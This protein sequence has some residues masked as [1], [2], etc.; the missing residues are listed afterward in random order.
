ME[1]KGTRAVVDE[2]ALSKSAAHLKAAKSVD[3]PDSLSYDRDVAQQYAALY[4]K[5]D[6]NL[7]DLF[8]ELDESPRK[9]LKHP[10]DDAHDF[11]IKYAQGYYTFAEE[12]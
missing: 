6:G 12:K 7:R 2:S 8:E 5:H 9:A 1:S 10:P 11:G 3:R 4:V